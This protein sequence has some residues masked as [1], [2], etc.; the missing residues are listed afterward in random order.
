MW[1]GAP[2]SSTASTAASA[3]AN[4][5][6]E[7]NPPSDVACMWA[8][9]STRP[10]PPEPARRSRRRRR[11]DP[12]SADAPHH[13]DSER[14]VPPL[15]PRDASGKL[16]E[17]L[18]DRVDGILARTPGAGTPGW[19]TTTSAPAALAI[20]AEWS[21]ILTAM[22]SF[23]PRSACPMNPGQ[24][25][26]NRQHDIHVARQLAE[27]PRR[28]RS[29][30]LNPPSKSISQADRLRQAAP[31]PLPPGSGK[32]RDGTRAGP[33]C[34]FR[35]MQGNSDMRRPIAL[36]TR[37]HAWKPITHRSARAR[38]RSSPHRS[39][40]R[41]RRHRRMVA[42]GGLRL[43]VLAHGK[44]YQGRPHRKRPP[45]SLCADHGYRVPERPSPC[46]RGRLNTS[47]TSSRARLTGR[48]P[49]PAATRRA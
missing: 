19:K 37:H 36:F 23:F 20:P 3:A 8:K 46:A 41:G 10:H 31:R 44:G 14:H 25:G 30:I 15:A 2:S 22:F 49:A 24:R 42:R 4:G 39:L 38:H 34:S 47:H 35:I 28:T 32:M 40:A 18:D 9:S 17:L 26:V 48:W 6:A 16:A 43:H 1:N 45:G 27:T 21:S 5:S 12:S 33:K 29:S 7:V 11:P 13:L